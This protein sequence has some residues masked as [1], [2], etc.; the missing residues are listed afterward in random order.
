M[1]RLKGKIAALRNLEGARRLLRTRFIDGDLARNEDGISVSPR[2][3][4]AYSFCALGAC[5]HVNGP[6][7]LLA[8][9]FLQQACRDVYNSDVD[10]Y[11]ST[12]RNGRLTNHDIFRV[13]DDLGKKSILHAFAQAI[14][15]LKAA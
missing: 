14:K 12:T 4:K 2:S 3:P 8:I 11:S 1:A 9:E 6:G 7:E 10:K 15:S 13:N 5:K